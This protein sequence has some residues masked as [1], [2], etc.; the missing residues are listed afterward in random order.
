[1]ASYD[2]AIKS[3]NR[4]FVYVSDFK[5]YSTIEVWKDQSELSR[6]KRIKDDCEGYAVAL[7]RLILGCEIWFVIAYGGGH[8]V[9]KLP[10]GKWIDCNIKKPVD[11]VPKEWD[12]SRGFK[13]SDE[14][15]EAKIEQGRALIV[16]KPKRFSSLAI[17]SK[18]SDIIFRIKINIIE[19]FGGDI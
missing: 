1:M 18:I 13:F 19:F 2:K 10:D 17:R 8:A 15:I 14:Q 11:I 12:F 16:I 7:W 3:L 6:Y 5:Q 9:V 4:R